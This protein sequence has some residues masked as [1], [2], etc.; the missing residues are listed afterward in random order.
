AVTTVL[1][2]NV[3]EGFA[4]AFKRRNVAVAQSLTSFPAPLPQNVLGY[5]YDTESG[6]YNPTLTGPAGLADAGTRIMLSFNS[7][8]TGVTLTVPTFV[9]LTGGSPSLTYPGIP[10]AG[11]T[12]EYLVLVSTDVT[13]APFSSTG[14]VAI[15]NGSGVAIYEVLT[16]DNSALETAT[17]PVT[18]VNV[19]TASLS[20]TTVAVS[21]SPLSAVITAD[22]VSPIPRF[23][24]SNPAAQPFYNL[25]PC[26]C[27]LL[28]PFVTN[29]AGFDTGIAISNTTLDPFGTIFQS[30]T[31]T[32]NYYGST[33]GGGA[34]PAK[35]V[36]AVI[37]AGGQ[38]VFTLSAGGGSV[39]S[40]P[41][42]QGYIIANAN[43]QY[44]HAFAFIS[45]LGA[46][47]LAEG[48]LAI[49]L[50]APGLN[51]TMVSG[52]VAAH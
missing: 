15:T 34:A 37:P 27:N 5:P 50:D 41:G 3:T 33:V 46:N 45:D 20:N 29:Q 38:L 32:L 26:T 13:Q 6:F 42:F 19:V 36:S 14:T 25:V 21:F 51:R 24:N 4:D 16:S 28:F 30:G 40:T 11:L 47:R 1:N 31:V 12:S 48:Y 23:I 8:G 2:V 22:T 44:C 52:E 10:G 35:Q 17:I 49:D 7:V 18:V 39:A 9:P 43:F